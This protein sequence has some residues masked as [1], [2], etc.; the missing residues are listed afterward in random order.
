MKKE[1]QE[2]ISWLDRTRDEF[3]QRKKQLEK[4][5]E[6]LTDSA[7][8]PTDGQTDDPEPSGRNGGTP[9]SSP[10]HKRPPSMDAAER[11]ASHFDG[12]KKMYTAADLEMISAYLRTQG[13][14]KYSRNPKLYTV[15]RLIGE[16]HV[17]NQ[18]VERGI[19]DSIIPLLTYD[20]LPP[21]INLEIARKFMGQRSVVLEG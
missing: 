9:S 20:S 13:E 18:F 3:D 11:F 2:M 14:G 12:S 19:S 8:D 17:F 4:M 6:A 15:L 7:T 10:P 5:M 21:A 1:I 16:L